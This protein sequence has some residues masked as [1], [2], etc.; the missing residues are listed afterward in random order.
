MNNFFVNRIILIA[1]LIIIL[2][3]SIYATI[4]LTKNEKNWIAENDYVR[5]FVSDNN[6]PYEFRNNQGYLTGINID[7]LREIFTKI[8]I[9]VIFSS[10]KESINQ[11][12]IITTLNSQLI[13]KKEFAATKSIY[14]INMSYISHKNDKDISNYSAI[15]LM[16]QNQ[17]DWVTT[18]ENNN[19][20]I[21]QFQNVQDVFYAFE[22]DTSGL[23]LIDNFFFWQLNELINKEKKQPYI[24]KNIK[25]KDIKLF[26]T[27][28]KPL[29]YNLVNKSLF[30]VYLNNTFK[31]IYDKWISDSN[32]EIF[33]HKNI[34][35]FYILFALNV[36]FVL[37][38]IGLIIRNFYH[39][40]DF[41]KII[42]EKNL[43]LSNINNELNFAKQALIIA[44]SKS[45][46]VLDHIDSI[47]ITV[48]LS[49]KIVYV[50]SIVKNILGYTSDE[51]IGQNLSKI[52]PDDSK[53]L[54]AIFYNQADRAKQGTDEIIIPSKDGL[55]KIF[56]YSTQLNKQLDGNYTINCI[57]QDITFR[58]S[59]ES[60]LEAY[61]DHLEDLVKQRTQRLRDSE[62][63]FRLVVENSK[64]GVFLLSENKILFCNSAVFKLTGYSS[65]ELIDNQ[66]SFHKLIFE[67]SYSSYQ[68]EFSLYHQ[69]KESVV[70]MDLI[71]VTKENKQFSAELILSPVI[72]N[73]QRV[74]LGIMRDVTEKKKIEKENLEKERL[75][76]LTHFAVTA[77]DRINSPLN[78][79]SGYTELIDSQIENK[80]SLLKN[81][82]SNIYLSV[83]IIENIMK[84]LKSL[85]RITIKDYKLDN[86]KVFDLDED[87][88]KYFPAS[89]EKNN[90]D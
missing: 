32:K 30:Q 6:A 53:K 46:D 41:V 90:G 15:Y 57:L 62:E 31:K 74:E 18:N 80:N 25:E 68:R 24:F 22:K 69:S 50:N 43:K 28:D 42:R 13:E 60:R 52:V 40:N 65:D 21:S 63:R 11:Y 89:E 75:S 61:T 87:V 10:E 70:T 5:I 33:Y 35:Q 72:Y 54:I 47:A 85:S 12:D 77:N 36:M 71:F 56:I 39:E 44:E 58:K 59:L 34:K 8:G 9:N 16:N 4:S 2:N 79:I 26:I 83:E 88:E 27:K 20:L 45:K 37:L 86:L 67:D 3:S 49:G 38:I 55:S 7:L 84:K 23:M 66:L 19:I 78:A 29:L 48:D 82:I 14:Q 17:L 73:G 1:V 76:I 81:A 51:L 64:S